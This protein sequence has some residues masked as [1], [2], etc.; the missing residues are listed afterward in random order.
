LPCI[1]FVPHFRKIS[2]KKMKNSNWKPHFII[3]YIPWI[4]LLNYSLLF[5][6][7]FAIFNCTM[8][9]VRWKL[10]F[11]SLLNISLL[12]MSKYL[13]LLSNAYNTVWWSETTFRNRVIS[14]LYVRLCKKVSGFYLIVYY[15][16]QIIDEISDWIGFL[17]VIKK[18]IKLNSNRQ[19]YR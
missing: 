12:C 5:D 7:T 4:C 18:T 10:A 15:F 17:Q 14:M 19:Y 3:F 16:S 13:Q 11:I 8:Q 9:N 2:K 1:Q 6:V